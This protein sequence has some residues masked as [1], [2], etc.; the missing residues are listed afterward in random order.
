MEKFFNANKERIFSFIDPISKLV[1]QGHT[2]AFPDRS[3][4]NTLAE[5][6]VVTHTNRTLYPPRANCS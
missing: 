5:V 3:F 1:S 6:L 4:D 2:A